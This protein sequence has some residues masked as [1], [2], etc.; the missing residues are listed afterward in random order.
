ME[1]ICTAAAGEDL[2][3]LLDMMRDYYAHDRIPFDQGV[4]RA[5]L[6]NL[7]EDRSLGRVFLIRAGGEV[8]GYLILT[9]DFGVES[10]GREV[11]IDELYLRPSSRGQGLGRAAL[12]FIETTARSWGMRAIHLGV[13]V[14]NR[15]AQEVY[16][17]FGFGAPT[18]YLMTKRLDAP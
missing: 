6:E 17:R 4:A 13:E 7:L 9:F 16:R 14:A 10:G 15:R 12:G 1:A 8:A 5:A 11:F 18:R 3:A 2:P